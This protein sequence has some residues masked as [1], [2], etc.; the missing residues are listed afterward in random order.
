ME[1]V[2]RG[3]AAKHPEVA[4]RCGELIETRQQLPE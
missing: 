1:Q 4:A 2:L 3:I